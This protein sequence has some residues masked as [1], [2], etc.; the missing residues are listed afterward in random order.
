MDHKIRKFITFVLLCSL[1]MSFASGFIPT[2]AT[3][4]HKSWN[5]NGRDCTQSACQVAATGWPIAYIWDKTWLSPTNSADWLGVLIGSDHV[6][7][8]GLV[9]NTFLWT[10]IV[11]IGSTL[12]KTSKRKPKS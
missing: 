7:L 1:A 2:E 11:L 3:V 8:A 12:R 4:T 9:K 6:N 5:N 10:L